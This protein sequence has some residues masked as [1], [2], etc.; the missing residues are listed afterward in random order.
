M[1]IKLDELYLKSMHAAD[2]LLLFA[3]FIS[4]TEQNF[5]LFQ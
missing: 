3:Y 1:Q 4:L 5:Y 2:R